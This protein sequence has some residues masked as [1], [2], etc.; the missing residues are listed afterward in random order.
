[1]KL[2]NSGENKID[3]FNGDTY[4]NPFEYTA[5]HKISNN[6][7]GVVWTFTNI[8]AI[9]LESS[10]NTA[11]DSGYTVSRNYKDNNVTWIQEE[12]ANVDN[13]YTQSTP[14]YV[15]NTAYSISRGIDI[16]TSKQ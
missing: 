2:Y 7:A 6:A 12:P 16:K 15:Y 14:Q 4:I 5:A 8:Y 3:V 9:P 11:L 10:I 1:M 13:I